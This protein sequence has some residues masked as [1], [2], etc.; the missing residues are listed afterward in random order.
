VTALAARLQ[1]LDGRLVFAV[2]AVA[3]FLVS[4]ALVHRGF[5]HAGELVDTPVYQHYGDR[6]MSGEVPYRDFDLEYPPGALPMFALP[7]LGAGRDYVTLFELLMATLGVVTVAL[8]AWVR[9]AAALYV[10]IAPLL[11]GSL[12]LSRFDLWPAALMTGALVALLKDRHGL[13]WGLLGAAV[14]AKLYPLVIVPLALVWT[15]RRA[16]LRDALWGVLVFAIVVVP[17][18]VIAP[19]GVWHS[20]HVQLARPLQIESLGAA[21]LMTFGNPPT[22]SSFGSQNISGHGWIAPLSL[23]VQ[24]AVLVALWVAFARRPHDLVRYSAACVVTFIAFGKVLSP[25]FLIWL[26]PL[27]PLVRGRRGL[28]ATGLLTLALVLTQLW[29]P[30]RYWDY[31]DYGQ[32]AGVVLVRD[33]ALVGLVGVLAFER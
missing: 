21:A 32:L 31:V 9:P 15:A 6:I 18:A 4:W 29:F 33:L 25:Q 23:V 27:V 28:A 30:M 13:G 20:V 24:V 11:V 16:R 10:A 7:S 19:G 12:I 3:I 17:F 2:T 5:Y 22:V 8:V 26:I 1:R 14:S